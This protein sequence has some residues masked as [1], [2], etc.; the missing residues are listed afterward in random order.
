MT[1]TENVGNAF[2]GG[3]NY[4]EAMPVSNRNLGGYKEYD[5]LLTLLKK[6][7]HSCKTEDCNQ[8]NKYLRFLNTYLS[9]DHKIQLMKCHKLKKDSVAHIY[10]KV[11]E[12]SMAATNHVLR[13]GY[14]RKSSSSRRKTSGGNRR[15]RSKNRH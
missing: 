7:H 2:N 6:L 11:K 12:L 1:H 9:D 3:S 15:T 14:T 4:S 8:A 10:R 13:W 5:D